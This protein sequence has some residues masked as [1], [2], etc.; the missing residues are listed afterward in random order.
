[1]LTIGHILAIDNDNLHSLVHR[2]PCSNI[3]VR[4]S[5]IA[6]SLLF[7]AAKLMKPLSVTQ[8]LEIFSLP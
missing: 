1:M 2:L 5:A 7:S 6:T 8:T 3:G 4:H